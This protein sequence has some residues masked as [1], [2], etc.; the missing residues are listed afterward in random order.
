MVVGGHQRAVAVDAIGHIF[1]GNIVI[2]RFVDENLHLIIS[3]D[4][5]VDDLGHAHLGA[6][7]LVLRVGLFAAL[8]EHEFEFIVVFG[9]NR[10]PTDIIDSVRVEVV[11]LGV[12][13]FFCTVIIISVYPFQAKIQITVMNE[14]C[15][16]FRLRAGRLHGRRVHCKQEGL[17][18]H[19]HLRGAVII[20]DFQIPV[21]LVRNIGD[22]IAM[23]IIIDLLDIKLCGPF[24]FIHIV[25]VPGGVIILDRAVVVLPDER[26]RIFQLIA[27]LFH[28]AQHGVAD[29]LGVR[30]R[31]RQEVRVIVI[32]VGHAGDA[33]AVA[34]HR[35]L[36]AR[37]EQEGVAA[38]AGIDIIPALGKTILIL[39]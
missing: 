19:S 34:H 9:I 25:I 22:H 4:L 36:N 20:E 7:V 26:L 30:M 24:H 13:I 33:V 18:A 2:H 21:A 5:R 35:I 32:D 23:P 12:I 39:V 38:V 15:L 10:I 3:V 29:L 37:A 8:H 27:I 1:L 17:S 31:C 11:G 14:V 6:G 28:H 16:L